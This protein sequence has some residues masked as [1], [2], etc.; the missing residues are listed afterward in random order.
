MKLKWFPG[1]CATGVYPTG[2]GVAGQR[3]GHTHLSPWTPGSLIC[4]PVGLPDQELLTWPALAVTL[5]SA[6]KPSKCTGSRPTPGLLIQT[7]LGAGREPGNLYRKKQNST[8]RAFR[9][10]PG[11]RTPRRDRRDPVPGASEWLWTVSCRG[12]GCRWH[13]PCGRV[14]GLDGSVCGGPST[15]PGTEQVS[16]AGSR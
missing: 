5:E 7:F 2:P 11:V 9:C 3:E 14:L 8:P 10:Q 13:Q 12:D 16:P 6:T 1:D 15:Q 4:E